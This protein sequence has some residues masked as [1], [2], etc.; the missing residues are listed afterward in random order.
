MGYFEISEAGGTVFAKEGLSLVELRM[1]HRAP[2]TGRDLGG[3][4]ARVGG[5]I[6]ANSG[7]RGWVGGVDGVSDFC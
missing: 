2:I 3:T 1:G 5:G 4:G 6:R 7:R